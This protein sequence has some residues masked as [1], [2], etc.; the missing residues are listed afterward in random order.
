MRKDYGPVF[1]LKNF[2]FYTSPF[3]NMKMENDIAAKVDV[4]LEG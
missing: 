1:M 2:P 4:I 3:W